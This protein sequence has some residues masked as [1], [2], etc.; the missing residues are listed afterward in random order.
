ME[1]Y[2]QCFQEVGYPHADLLVL[3]VGDGRGNLFSVRLGQMQHRPQ[4]GGNGRRFG[5]LGLGSWLICIR[6]NGFGFRLRRRL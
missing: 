4:R 6:K 2:L 5:G 1:P 3:I